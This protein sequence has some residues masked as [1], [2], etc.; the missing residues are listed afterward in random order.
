MA[1]GDLVVKGRQRPGKGG[2]GIAVD[3]DHIRLQGVNGL[4]H[5][6]QALA[7]NGGQ[8]LAGS[9]DIQVPVRLQVKDFQ[10]TVQHLA[11]LGSHAAKALNL[12][13]GSQFFYQGTHFDGLRPGAED[14]HDTQLVHYA[15]PSFF[16]SV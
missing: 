6:Q 3:Q 11:V 1:H 9:H 5:A 12:R 2:G 10:H 4:V 13:P 15:S 14:A 7:G 16:S 8:G